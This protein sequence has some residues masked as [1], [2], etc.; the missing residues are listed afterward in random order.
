M[1]RFLAFAIVPV[2]ALAL[3][4]ARPAS[5]QLSW[6]ADLGLY[7]SYVWRGVTYTSRFVVQPDLWLSLPV[8][9]GSITVG[10]WANIEPGKYDGT[11]DIS[12]GGGQAGPDLAEFDWWAEYGRTVGK[13]DLILGATGYYY[14]NPA[15]NAGLALTNDIKTIEIYGRFGFDAPLSPRLSIYY[16]V[17]KIKGAYFEG[18]INHSFPLSPSF[19]LDLGALAGW[20]AGQEV[21]S[22]DPSYVFA[23]D[24]LT[25]VDLSAATSFSLGAL[26][27]TPAFHFVI[28]NDDNTKFT[29]LTDTSDTKIW[30]G[31]SIS[32]EGGGEVEEAAE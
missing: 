24:G 6:G 3:V 4:T 2:L 31:A 18:S 7:S 10:G 5:A 30:F 21:S 13:L 23:N 28:A 11:N 22:N 32:W 9:S 26:S 29:N 8:G 17:D 16:D 25:H 14:P 19:S 12:E 1:R 27:I 20:S 15:D